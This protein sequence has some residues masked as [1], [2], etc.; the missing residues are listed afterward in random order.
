VTRGR[1]PG[2]GVSAP[3]VVEERSA[4]VESLS[5]TEDLGKV[6]RGWRKMLGHPEQYGDIIPVLIQRKRDMEEKHEHEIRAERSS[7]EAERREHELRAAVMTERIAEDRRQYDEHIRHLRETIGWVEPS[8]Y[9]EVP[10]AIGRPPASTVRMC[11]RTAP[12]GPR[13]RKPEAMLSSLR[14]S[15]RSAQRSWP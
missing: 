15:G 8:G 5:S 7:W 10:T 14:R 4:S 9:A 2:L 11:T 3:T 1:H 12:E 13:S 6:T